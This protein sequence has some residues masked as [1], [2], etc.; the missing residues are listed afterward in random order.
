LEI[1]DGAGRVLDDVNGQPA[2]AN[3]PLSQSVSSVSI[4]INGNLNGFGGRVTL[5]N[6]NGIRDTIDI[7][8]TAQNEIT[9]LLSAYNDGLNTP[10]C[11]TG[12]CAFEVPGQKENVSLIFYRPLSFS[13]FVEHDALTLPEPSTAALL[14]TGFGV[15]SG[16]RRRNRSL[17]KSSPPAPR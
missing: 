5:E 1:T 14:A 12:L 11:V 2:I 3:T 15:L 16:V 9:V 10:S 17:R 7:T 8:Q 13:V 4:V 6:S